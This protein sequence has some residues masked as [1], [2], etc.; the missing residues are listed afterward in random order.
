MLVVYVWTVKRERDRRDVQ[1]RDGP[2]PA[3]GAMEL[4]ELYDLHSP[5]VFGLA[6]RVTGS[7]EAAEEITQDVFLR[8]WRDDSTFD[9]ERG[10][11]RSWLCMVAHGLAVTWVRREVSQRERLLRTRSAEVS[12][13]NLEESPVEA[14]FEMRSAADGA[15]ASLMELTPVQRE[16]LSLVYFEGLTHRELADALGIPLGTAKS[17]VRDSLQRL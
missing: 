2:G 1:S 13:W 4:A 7:R 8:L 6:R 10:S 15:R 5:V 17:R 14:D 11:V 16:S 9:P 3:M 12:G